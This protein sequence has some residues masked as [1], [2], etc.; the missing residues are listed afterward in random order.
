VRPGPNPVIWGHPCPS[1][2]NSRTKQQQTT[3]TRTA[4]RRRTFFFLF[5]KEMV[6]ERKEFSFFL[7]RTRKKCFVDPN[8]TRHTQNNN[9]NITRER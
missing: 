3:T 4:K 8:N 6:K 9:K 2:Y 7:F 1:S 5:K